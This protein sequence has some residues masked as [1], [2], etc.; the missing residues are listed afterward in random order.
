MRQDSNLTLRMWDDE[1]WSTLVGHNRVN[2]LN[3][4]DRS[5]VEIGFLAI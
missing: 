3:L 4:E 2:Y 1:I 5:S